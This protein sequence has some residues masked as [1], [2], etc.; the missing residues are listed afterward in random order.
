MQELLYHTSN[1]FRLFQDI[2]STG[3]AGSC[4]VRLQ[5]GQVSVEV[6]ARVVL[7]PC[8]GM[9]LEYAGHCIDRDMPPSVR[10]ER[11]QKD[12]KR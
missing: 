5:F 12:I 3:L 7:G 1:V 6:S 4:W 10:P 11:C 2:H 9:A 8:R